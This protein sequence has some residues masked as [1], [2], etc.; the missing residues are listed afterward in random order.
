VLAIMGIVNA[1]NGKT[2]PLP[3]I[4]KYAEKFKI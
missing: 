2:E 3:V 1:L 4:G